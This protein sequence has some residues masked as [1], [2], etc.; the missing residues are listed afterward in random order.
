MVT[1]A[2]IRSINRA[3]N[4]CIVRMPLFE[5]A[6]SSAHV[7]AEASVSITPGLFNNLFVGDVVIVAFE[8]NALEKPVVLGKLFT[9][10]AAENTAHGGAAIFDSLRVSATATIPAS[11]TFDFPATTKN[12]YKDLKTPK[13]MADYIKWLE[14]L[15]KKLANQL[16]DQF[17]CFK[18]WA[19]WQLRPENIEVDDGDIDTGYHVAVPCLYQTENEHCNICGNNCTKSKTRRYTKVDIDKTYPNI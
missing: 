11:S 9:G 16:D 12:E 1:K 18:N 13:K 14:R 19:Q 15:V 2:I 4:R 5:S 17:R 6:S 10:T 7:E 8:E 3:G